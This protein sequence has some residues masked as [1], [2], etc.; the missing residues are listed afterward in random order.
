MFANAGSSPNGLNVSDA[1]WY[2]N[3]AY[4]HPFVFGN[5]FESFTMNDTSLSGP[6]TVAA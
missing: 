2:L 6:G 3:M 5:R 4:P 1:A